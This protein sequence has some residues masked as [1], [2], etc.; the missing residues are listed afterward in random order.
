MAEEYLQGV[1]A[2]V[3]IGTKPPVSFFAYPGKK[4]YL[5]PDGAQLIE[6]SSPYEDGKLE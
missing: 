5:S 6:L 4:S 2:I 3:F 1:E